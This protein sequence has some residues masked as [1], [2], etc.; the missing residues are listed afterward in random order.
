MIHEIVVAKLSEKVNI[1]AKILASIEFFSK[2]QKIVML[3][4]KTPH[5]ILILEDIQRTEIIFK[6][7]LFMFSINLLSMS[8]IKMSVS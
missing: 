1:K 4:I 5:I 6:Y 8:A 2:I 3:Q 7:P